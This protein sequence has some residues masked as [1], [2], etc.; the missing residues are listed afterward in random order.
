M[1]AGKSFEWG[2]PTTVS[3]PGVE[4]HAI[5]YSPD[6][7]VMSILFAN[8]GLQLQSKPDGSTGGLCATHIRLPFTL[9]DEE[10]LS[11]I[12]ATIRTH[13]VYG[14]VQPAAGT[15]GDNSARGTVTSLTS[16]AIILSLGGTVRS[17]DFAPL[18]IVDTEG[19]L[20]ALHQM[21]IQPLSNAPNRQVPPA[22]D[23]S[24][25]VIGHRPQSNEQLMIA[26]D[27]LDLY[28]IIERPA[29]SA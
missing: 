25:V 13:V 9:A 22:I 14:S 28:T 11:A 3:T 18:Q 20:T 4:V 7:R 21:D 15:D 6:K 8:N 17:C 12:G 16:A 26:V 10:G 23:V 27:S 2:E 29:A 5:T 24:I 1:M 19:S